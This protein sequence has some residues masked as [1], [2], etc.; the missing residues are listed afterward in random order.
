[1]NSLKDWTKY[2]TKKNT[3]QFKLKHFAVVSLLMLTVCFLHTSD[4]ITISQFLWAGL[5]TGI[6]VSLYSLVKT[7]KLFCLLDSA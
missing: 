4:L 2:L 5:E 6:S 1:M 7:S 3:L